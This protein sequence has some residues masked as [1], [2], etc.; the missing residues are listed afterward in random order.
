MNKM[1]ISVAEMANL[2]GIS[3]TTAY[4]LIGRDDFP[5]TRLGK[6]VVIPLDALKEWLERGGTE[7]RDDK[8]V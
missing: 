1:A 2:L 6:R 4:E 8:A 3:R 7:P 5:S